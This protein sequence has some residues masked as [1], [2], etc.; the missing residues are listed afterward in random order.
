LNDAKEADRFPQ[1]SADQSLTRLAASNRC[2]LSFETAP[3]SHTSTKAVLGPRRLKPSRLG[4]LITKSQ[5]RIVF[6]ACAVT[7]V[8]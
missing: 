6:R 7:T 4:F 8:A 5:L 2:L 1:V 3:P